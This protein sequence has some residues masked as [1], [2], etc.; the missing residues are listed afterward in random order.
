MSL[1]ELL[2]SSKNGVVD[3]R[4]RKFVSETPIVLTSPIS[5]LGGG[6]CDLELRTPPGVPAFQIHSDNVSLR[7]LTIRHVL[8]KP[9]INDLCVKVR[10]TG[11][12]ISDCKIEF[13][14]RAVGGSVGCMK[15]ENTHFHNM[16]PKESVNVVKAIVLD[17]ILGDIVVQ[18][19]KHTTEGNP[20]IE[21]FVVV[22]K[23]GSRKGGKILYENN[24]TEGFTGVRKW[25]NFDVG[26]EIGEEGENLQMVIRNN[27]IETSNS[28]LMVIQPAFSKSLYRFQE[29]VFENNQLSSL[30]NILEINSMYSGCSALG[31]PD[32]LNPFIRFNKNQGYENLVKFVGYKTLPKSQLWE[33]GVQKNILGGG[34]EIGTKS[35]E[36]T[37]VQK[38][39]ILSTP[40]II[41]ILGVIFL[42]LIIL[43]FTST[44]PN[45]KPVIKKEKP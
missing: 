45:R 12:V 42:A 31:E 29:L 8:E 22:P 30:P 20:R 5:I 27:R 34:K 23:T 39:N 43:Y 36:E 37:P 25:I 6:D 41:T 9:G 2:Q 38:K 15:I 44:S 26:A 24:F 14:K 28:S 13:S 17:Q 3:L 21:G 16:L 33:E 10:G 4:G 1:Q 32:S 7:G 35:E 18:G 11:I 40:V 19:C